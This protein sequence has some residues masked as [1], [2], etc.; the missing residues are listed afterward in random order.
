[1]GG[2]PAQTGVTVIAP[3]PPFRGG[4]ARHSLALCN[5]LVARG[6]VRLSIESFDRLYPQ[7][8]YP[9][10]S[11]RSTDVALPSTMQAAY[12]LDTVN[13]IGWRNVAD[14]IVRR[15]D[16]IAV[17]PAWTFFTAPVLGYLA[18][19]LRRNGVHTVMVVHNAN[20]HEAAGWKNRLLAWQISAADRFVTHT[21]ALAQDL[22]TIAPTT[23]STIIAHPPFTDFP[24]AKGN[25]HQEFALEL[26]MFG[27][28]RPYKG[29][30]L[31]IDALSAS[32]RKDIRLTVAG[33]FWQDVAETRAKIDRLGL[34]RQ[35]EII[36]RYV[37]DQ[38]A[39]ELFSRSDAVLAPYLSVTGSGVVALATHYGRPVIASNLPGLAE[40]IRDGDNGWLFECGSVDALCDLLQHRVDRSKAREFAANV[41]ADADDG[42]DRFAAALLGK[43]A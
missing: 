33:E 3:V 4:I 26:L 39:A 19:R 6:D 31:A 21:T 36:P 25:L 2:V 16:T 15:G 13:P 12:V 37:A 1:M 24:A 23:P 30:D 17:L 38:E 10:D 20:D 7:F 8:L 27:L 28:V 29:L 22:A 41:K 14:A 35:I 42:W 43:V 9:G 34:T 40:C 18:R 5:A 11:D 32:N